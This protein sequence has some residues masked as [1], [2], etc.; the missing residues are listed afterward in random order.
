MLG[1]MADH[2][3][4][5]PERLPDGYRV[6]AVRLTGEHDDVLEVDLAGP[7]GRV[8]LTEQRGVLDVASLGPV[9]ERTIDGRTLYVL[10]RV[11]WHAVWQSDDTVVSIVSEA[12][13]DEVADVVEA[14]PVTG[15]DDGLPA[16]LTRGW[17]TVTGALASP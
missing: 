1:W 9:E 8:V 14:F 7:D 4:T 5:E 12:S 13:G 15:Y 2:G 6:T 16:R 11:P 3:W 17:D 10:S